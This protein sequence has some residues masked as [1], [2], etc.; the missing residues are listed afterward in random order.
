MKRVQGRSFPQSLETALAQACTCRYLRSEG[1]MISAKMLGPLGR[2]SA[3][4]THAP[5]LAAV[6]YCNILGAMPSWHSPKNRCGAC[7]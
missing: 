3:S 7:S 6:S 5:A 1:E 2:A 4:R